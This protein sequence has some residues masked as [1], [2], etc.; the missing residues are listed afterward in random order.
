[1]EFQSYYLPRFLTWLFSGNDLDEEING[2][3]L[4]D[5]AQGN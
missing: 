3:I 5:F 1:M 4:D 2:E